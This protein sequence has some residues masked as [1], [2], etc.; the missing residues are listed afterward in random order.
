MQTW[1]S[2]VDYDKELF[3]GKMEDEDYE[4]EESSESGDEDRIKFYGMDQNEIGDITR[5][6]ISN[7]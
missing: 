6:P 5:I 7:K 1:T 3:N 4:E 2:G